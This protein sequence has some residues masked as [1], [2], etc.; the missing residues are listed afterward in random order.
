MFLPQPLD[1][2]QVLG[3]G[4]KLGGTVMLL[5]VEMI[6]GWGPLHLVGLM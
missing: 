6:T 1:G 2:I 5:L 4:D 3:V